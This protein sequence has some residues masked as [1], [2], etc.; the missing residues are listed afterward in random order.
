MGLVKS[1]AL[2]LTDAV[3][4]K[5]SIVDYVKKNSIQAGYIAT[6]VGGLSEARI[7]MPGARDYKQLSEDLEIVSV[8]GTLSPDG[9]HIHMSVSDKEG[10]VIGGHLA[11]GCRVRLTAEVVMIEDSHHR[12]SREWDRSTGYQELV[13]QRVSESRVH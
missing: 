8:V 13:I 2:R 12:F 9:C 3:D 10:N 11:T 5:E 1:H 6:C 4:L 7:R